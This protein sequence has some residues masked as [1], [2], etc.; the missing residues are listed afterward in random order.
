MEALATVLRAHGARSFLASVAGTV[1]SEGV[2]ADGRGWQLAIEVP[3]GSG[4]PGRRLAAADQVVSTSGAYRRYREVGGR[5]FS[6][7]LD[8]RTGAP[9]THRGV[10][11][12]VVLP[13]GESAIRADA[14]ATALNVLGPDDGLGLA[15]RQ[16]WAVCY[17]E[18]A[19][20][21]VKARWS[22]AFAPHLAG[23]E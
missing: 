3:D 16:G 19:G 17:L 8:A 12:T 11:V 4:R 13:P 6:H 15:A 22:P 10:S 20:E 23:A 18:A 21:G 14:L 5:R 2:R 9:V 7:T 1:R